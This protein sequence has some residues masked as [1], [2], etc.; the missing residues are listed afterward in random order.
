MTGWYWPLL[1]WWGAV[2]C[3]G[4]GLRDM[5]AVMNPGLPAWLSCLW[6]GFRYLFGAI[7]IAVAIQIAVFAGALWMRSWTESRRQGRAR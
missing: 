6:A 2:L 4:M 3:A 5:R 1:L 7:E